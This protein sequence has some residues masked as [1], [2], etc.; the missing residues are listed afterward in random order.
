MRRRRSGRRTGEAVGAARWAGVRW[1]RG[2]NGATRQAAIAAAS[3]GARPRPG[4]GGPRSARP[5]LQARATG[6]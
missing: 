5:G 6:R 1:P 4:S 3:A 2:L